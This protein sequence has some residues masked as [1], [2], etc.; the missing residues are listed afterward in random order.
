MTD[1]TDVTVDRRPRLPARLAERP[2]LLRQLDRMAPVTIIRA[3]AG[4]GKTT[5]V[6]RWTQG[7][8]DTHVIWMRV[9]SRSTGASLRAQLAA[10]LLA[11]PAVVRTLIVFDEAHLI[12]DVRLIEDVVEQVAADPD[13][14]LVFC[15]HSSHAVLA[16]ARRHHLETNVVTGRDLTI[17]AAEIPAFAEAWGHTVSPDRAAQLQGV[18]QG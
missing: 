14:H 7:L 15:G 16:A 2:E 5:L 9:S 4:H 13:V 18:M 12:D 6:A 11:P 3:L 17:T 10:S 1:L 8:T